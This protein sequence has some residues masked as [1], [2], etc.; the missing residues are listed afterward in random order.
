MKG[1]FLFIFEGY[2]RADVTIMLQF[3]ESV[4]KT[5]CILQEGMSTGNRFHIMSVSWITTPLSRSA[6]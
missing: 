4:D 3:T 6:C 2:L 1:R 5:L